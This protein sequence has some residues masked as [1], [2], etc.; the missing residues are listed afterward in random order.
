MI[1]RTKILQEVM[2]MRFECTYDKYKK[3]KLT[4]EEAAVLLGCSVRTFRRKK[5]RYEASGFKG[6]LDLRT[7]KTPANKVSQDTTDRVL[8]LYKHSYYD[9]TAKHFYEQLLKK[10][11]YKH[12]YN[13]TRLTLQQHGLIAKSFKRDEHRKK[14]QRRSMAGM[15]LHQDG[16]THEW[17]IGLGYKVDLI[18]TMDD[19]TNEIYSA[20]F[21]EQEG[22]AS[23]FIALKEVITTKGLFSSLYVDRGSH[24]AY[25]P[26]AGGKVDKSSPTQVGRACAQLGI[27]LI[28]A[29]S[30]EARGRSE[31]LFGSWQNR[32]PQ[33][34]RI[35]NITTIED[36]NRYLKD[37][38][39]ADYNSKFS[40]KPLEDETTFVPYVGRDLEDILCIQ[41]ERIVA[42][43]NTISYKNKTLQIPANQHR[44]HYVK[45]Q[46][47]VHEYTHGDLAIFYGPR[48][49][50]TYAANND[51]FIKTV[52]ENVA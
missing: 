41:E 42:K 40:V 26:K 52:N 18:V 45:C 19:A 21:V 24:Y 28:H 37:V 46:V 32:L 31:R 14:R 36:A 4:M 23:T 16:S 30:P 34:L 9:F 7:G 35:N 22:T 15:M 8:N 11:D 47:M 39:I 1:S 5:C 10:H 3:R 44:Y 49:I 17:I 48:K 13:F 25:T 50:A 6:L 51:L 12:S 20:F 29:Y 33:E 43:D 2:K 38:F 27:Q